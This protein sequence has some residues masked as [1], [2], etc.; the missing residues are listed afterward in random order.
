[1][2][3]ENKKLYLDFEGLETY[4]RLI[5]AYLKKI[6]D[7]DDAA[8]A[9]IKEGLELLKGIVKAD[10]AELSEAIQVNKTLINANSDEIQKNTD[11][12]EI[13]N[14]DDKIA[15]SVANQVKDAIDALVNGAPEALD[16]LKEIADWIAEDESGT[17]SIVEK[18]TGMQKSIS[19]NADAIEQNTEEIA[20]T[21][22]NIVDLKSYVDIKD[23]FYYDSI[24]AIAQLNIEMLFKTKVEVASIDF[25]DKLSNI[26]AD[27]IIVLPNDSVIAEDVVIPTGAVIDAKGSLFSGQ[28]TLESDNVVIIN[29]KFLKPV[30]VEG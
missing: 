29:A 25:I 21:K 6:D 10:K 24:D 28:V 1:M 23:K 16:T 3:M 27:E 15:G 12:I 22:Q 8:V 30:K 26:S 4:D 11:A 2:D 9:D 14:G 17:A 19:D 5:K 7:D 13:L 20:A 18:L